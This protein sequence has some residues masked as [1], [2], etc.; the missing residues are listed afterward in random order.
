MT[1]RSLATWVRR[2]ILRRRSDDGD[3][4]EEIRFHLA[5][6]TAR[7]AAQGGPLS[8]A[9]RGA[10]LALGGA[11]LVKERTRAVWVSSTV[12]QLAQDLRY[13]VRILRRSP[14]LSATVVTL[15]ALVIGGNTTVFSIANGIL[16]NPMPGVRANGLMSL[17]WVAEDGFIE[18]HNTDRVYSHFVEHATTLRPVAAFDRMTAAMTHEHGSAVIRLGVVSANYFETLG[19]PLVKGRAFSAD[20]A[21]GASGLAVVI[22]HQLWQAA[23][24]GAEDIIGRPLILNRR[25]ATVV[26]V[27]DSAFRGAVL[28]EQIDL[29]V[30]VG[31]GFHRRLMDGFPRPLDPDGT[32]SVAMIGRLASGR[33]PAEAQAELTTLWQQVQSES[34][35]TEKFRVR[36]TPYSGVAAGN[37]LTAIYGNRM[38]AIF[39]IVTLLTIAIVCANVANLLI[40][41]AAARQ[42]EIAL[43]QSLG[44]S[45]LRIVRSLLAE[46][47]VLSLVA[48]TAACLFAWWVS[49]AATAGLLDDVESAGPIVLPD[50]TPDWTVITYALVLA[51]LCT[52]AFTV[53]PALRVWREQLLPF[54]KVGEQGVVQARSNLS[55]A[56]VVLQLAFSVLLL[57]T[58]GLAQRSLSLGRTF[59]PGF[60]TRNILLTDVNTAG[61]TD[62]PETT[63]ALLEAIQS[64]LSRLPGI[65]GVAHV[66]ELLQGWVNF[67]VRR[68]GS[69]AR[70]LATDHRV[71][72]G[73][74]T[75]INVPFVAGA[76]FDGRSRTVIVTES[77]AG[78]LW[79]GESA[80][81]KTLIAGP[82]WRDAGEGV[83]VEV[84]GVVR[85]AY[86]NGQANETPPRFIFFQVD[87]RS[88][89]SR[90][91]FY[92]RHQGSAEIVAP[93][94]SRALREVNSAVAIGDLRSFE[95]QIARRIAPIRMIT[96]LLTMFAGVS[97]LIAAIG[98]YAVVWFDGRRRVREFGLRLALGA[99]TERV[100]RSVLA[101]NV[102]STMSGL[103]IGFLLSVAVGA[104]LA[105]FLYGVTATDPITYAGVF[106]ILAASLVACYLPARRAS[107]VDPMIALRTE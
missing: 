74:F 4:D 38:I 89:S 62:S 45:R 107:R 95:T 20:E 86:F 33:S 44:A 2:S 50:L 66:P 42:R 1:L 19:V 76:D 68:D 84:I 23:F 24:Q 91:T 34:S 72:P 94:V 36:L 57:T 100:I 11:A 102:G 15:V 67:P 98:Q 104:I 21:R 56:L 80:V 51:A 43:R 49:R 71:M 52:I 83:E 5:Q 26:G 30:P 12:E 64:R 41:R 92:L 28:G 7:R 90:A 65:D 29:W 106:L 10:R 87:A 63:R 85:D 32:V 18:T 99:S 3:L 70:V 39:S 105:R 75:A 82:S 79:P 69:S 60:A 54:L 31:T 78:A 9:A 103:L 27:A 40:A 96:S 25:P 13:G 93:A 88:F 59:D 101:E 97:L 61:A 73:Y 17:S 8:E 47:L 22:A 46:G 58:A 35:V 81:G 14:G 16:R 55:R 48:W 53:A 6:E 77:L 37:S